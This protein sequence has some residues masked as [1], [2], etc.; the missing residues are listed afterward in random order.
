MSDLREMSRRMIELGYRQLAKDLHPDVGGSEEKMK[1]ANLAREYALEA[2]SLAPPDQQGVQFGFRAQAEPVPS[3]PIII[4]ITHELIPA[5]ATAQ[6][7]C[8]RKGAQLIMVRMQSM[9]D[10]GP[11]S[12]IGMLGA[13]FEQFLSPPKAKANKKRRRRV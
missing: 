5:L 4:E 1:Q 3:K 13:V 6:T 8:F 10:P 2:C 11:A 12:L 7:L 9:F